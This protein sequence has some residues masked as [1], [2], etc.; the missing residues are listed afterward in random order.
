MDVC[1]TADFT[2]I[3]QVDCLMSY[4]QK[5]FS[6]WRPSVILNFKKI[7]FDHL[8]V[9]E[10]QICWPIGLPNFIKIG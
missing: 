2:E 4:G 5:T 3:E 7:I 10:F 6:I 1:P 9:T 8:T